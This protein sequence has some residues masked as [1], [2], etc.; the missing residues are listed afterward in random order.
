VVRYHKGGLLQ[1][2]RNHRIQEPFEVTTARKY[3]FVLC[4]L[5]SLSAFAD[6]A[7]AQQAEP[8]SYA[9]FE[10]WRQ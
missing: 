7:L 6:A 10:K 9:G 4:I 3:W 2:Q 1:L 5:I 8:D